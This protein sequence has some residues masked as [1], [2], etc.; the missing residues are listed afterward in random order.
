[1]K[2][3][4]ATL[5]IATTALTF[6]AQADTLTETC[7]SYHKLAT[8]IMRNRQE[9]ISVVKMMGA[10]S[11]SKLAQLMVQA[12]YDSPRYSTDRMKIKS[13]TTFAN[14]WATACFKYHGKKK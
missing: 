10:A 3:L 12:A 11:E 8:S 7:A 14:N 4:I 6:N 5:A 1:M 9:G 13:I 2:K